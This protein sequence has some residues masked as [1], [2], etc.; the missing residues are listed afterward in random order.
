[1]S[2]LNFIII[3]KEGDIKKVGRANTKKD[4]IESAS[5]QYGKLIDML[6]SISKKAIDKPFSFNIDGRKEAHWK[7]DNNLRD[8]IVHLYEWHQL[9]LDWVKSNMNDGN[10]PFL[11]APYNWKTYGDLNIEFW[12]KHQNTSYNQA[13]NL[14]VHSHEDV[15]KMIGDVSSDELFAKGRFKWTGGSTLGAYCVSATA[16]HYEWAIKK[17]KMHIATL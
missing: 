14:I 9:L 2:I 11:P 17:I 7:R 13:L 15:M 5:K 1:M 8:V 12:K 10:Q 3:F 4:L 6:N 16:S